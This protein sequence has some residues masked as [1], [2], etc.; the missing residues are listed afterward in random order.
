MS[1]NTPQNHT[2]QPLKSCCEQ[3]IRSGMRFHL[4]PCSNP[5][6][7]TRNGKHYCRVHDPEAVAEREKERSRK[8]NDRL[9]MAQRERTCR[10]FCAGIPSDQLPAGG[11]AK[12]IEE[13]NDLLAGLALMK[14]HYTDLSSSNPGFL[15]KLVLQ[16]Y[17]LFNEAMEAMNKL[18]SRQPFKPALTRP[19]CDCGNSEASWH[20]DR[21]GHRFYSCNDCARAVLDKREKGGAV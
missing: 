21:H 15:G 1:E 5:Y 9:A 14:A 7:V 3:V 12:V 13:R 18:L 19:I 11:L 16:D 6:H 20:G 8:L 17:R 4:F 2:A 10:A